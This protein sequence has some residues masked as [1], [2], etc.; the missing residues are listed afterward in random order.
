MSPRPDPDTLDYARAAA[1]I[2]YLREEAPRQPSLAEVAAQVHL[3]PAYF[4]RLFTAWAGLSPKQFART[5]TV[6]YAKRLLADRHDQPSLFTVTDQVRLSSP[7]RLH[8]AFVRLE[9]VTPGEFASGGNGVDIRY[10]FAETR[11]GESLIASTPRGI[12]SL[13]FGEDKEQALQVLRKR[14]PCANLREEGLNEQQIIAL[15]IVNGAAGAPA[16]P[17]SVHVQGSPFQV[18][19]WRALLSIPCGEVTTYGQLGQTLGKPSAAQAIGG[20]VGANRIAWLI[21]C[22]RVLRSDGDLSGYTWGPERKAAML[23]I[24]AGLQKNFNRLIKT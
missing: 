3:S 10:A 22:H 14:Y 21:P 4:Q 5:L 8:D 7:S 24:E 1:A 9:A 12:C 17:L 18:Q 23:G 20:A 19:V 16:K 15:N 2:R 13:S 11:F 6:E